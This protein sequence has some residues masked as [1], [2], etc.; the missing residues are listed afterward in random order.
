[1]QRPLTDGQKRLL[2]F[3]AK[4]P[5]W[6]SFTSLELIRLLKTDDFIVVPSL[7]EM[8]LVEHNSKI[9]AVRI[10]A[11]GRVIAEETA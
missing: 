6:H 10:T 3:L 11:A 2:R 5:E 7:I 9:K 4:Y 8:K 1:M